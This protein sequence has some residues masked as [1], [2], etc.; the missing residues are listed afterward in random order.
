VP[1]SRIEEMTGLDFH[2]LREHDAL[3][4]EESEILES[5][6]GLLEVESFEDP[7]L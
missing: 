6:G 7:K 4:G 1:I 3:A 5:S 2:H